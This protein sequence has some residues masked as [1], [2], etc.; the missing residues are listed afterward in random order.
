MV[1]VEN[2]EG[3]DAE[4]EVVSALGDGSSIGEQADAGGGYAIARGVLDEVHGFVGE[5]QEF[6]FRARVR[7]VRCD[8]DACGDLHVDSRFSEPDGFADQFVQAAGNSEGVFFRSL[9]QQDDELVAAVAEGEIDH[10][11]FF[12]DGSA[13]FGEELRTH[14]VAVGV[15]HVFKMVEVDEDQGKLERV[16]VRAVDFRIEHEIQ[17]ARIVKAGAIVSDRQF[18]DSLDVARILDGDCGVIGERFE[19]SKIALAEPFG[20]DTV[21]EFDDAEAMVAEAHWNGDDRARLHFCALVNFREETRIFRG[22]GNDDDF[23]CLGDPAGKSLPQFDTDIFQRFGAF[24]CRDLKIEFAFIGVH[25]QQRPRIGPQDLVN[26]LHDGAKNL[27]ELE[28]RGESLA[29]LMENSD[30]GGFGRLGHRARISAP[31]D[32]AEDF[33]I[34]GSSDRFSR[35]TGNRVWD[36]IGQR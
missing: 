34:V 33:A 7:R 15:V 10:A 27:V 14:Q 28:R 36:L 13:D 11:A 2:A 19:K 26:L 8:A 23:T 30:F 9:W 32:A 17:M 31:L 18:M 5:M 12:F 24:T 20:A 21:D 29:K 35:K 3:D 16:P 22:V 25:E 4:R 6:G 1:L